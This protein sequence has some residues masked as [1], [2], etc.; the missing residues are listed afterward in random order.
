MALLF[1]DENFPIPSV[2]ILRQ[3]GHDVQ[4][5]LQTGQAGLAVPDDE[6]LTLSTSLNRC[7]LTLNRKDFIKLHKQKPNHAGII[8]CKADADFMA[9]AQRIDICLTNLGGPATGQLLRVQ[10]NTL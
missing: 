7:L 5:L 8:I 1:A 4:T 10:R 9:L 3:L 6:V 2:V